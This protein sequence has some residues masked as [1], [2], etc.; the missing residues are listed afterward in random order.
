MF[1]SCYPVG[2][3]SCSLIIHFGVLE[4][5]LFVLVFLKEPTINSALLLINQIA[6]S[7]S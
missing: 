4:V 3:L 7:A 2:F 5:I 6:S 1:W